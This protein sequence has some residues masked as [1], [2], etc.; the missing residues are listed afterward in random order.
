MDFGSNGAV[1]ITINGA[2]ANAD[3]AC[4]EVRLGSN[5][6]PL[7]TTANFKN[8][9]DWTTY[10]SQTFEIPRTVGTKDIVLV[11]LNG[12]FAFH[13]FQF[14][15]TD[16]RYMNPYEQLEPEAAAEDIEIADIDGGSH[17]IMQNYVSEIKDQVAIKFNNV[18]FGE[19]GS[20]LVVIKGRALGNADVKASI[21]YKD[22]DGN[23][24]SI[25]I[26]FRAGKGESYELSSETFYAQTFVAQ[27]IKGE[28]DLV[29]AFEKGTWFDLE[30]LYFLEYGTIGERPGDITE[31]KNLID[32]AAQLIESEYTPETWKLLQDALTMAEGF[33]SGNPY[34]TQT[35][36][37]EAVRT[38]EEAIVGLEEVEAMSEEELRKQIES[39]RETIRQ[40]EGRLDTANRKLEQ[41]NSELTEANQKLAKALKEL[42][43]AKAQKQEKTDGSVN[44]IAKMQKPSVKKGKEGTLKISW[45]KLANVRGY[46]IQYAT[47]KKFKGAKTKKVNA[48]KSSLVLKKL[49]KG[50]KYYVRIRAYR[51][52]KDYELYGAYSSA[53]SCKVKTKKKV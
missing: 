19:N 31:L 33:L 22:A 45:K 25:P 30:S 36:I 2:N 28:Q 32:S 11:F 29:V 26:I 13:Y 17:N 9:G 44:K 46:E 23:M 20:D 53:K 47:N 18:D 38:V 48:K 51:S 5:T 7:L 21:Q 27:G 52:A 40:L 12:S 3:D 1:K 4:I 42:E 24:Q 8:T 34:Y 14:T 35:Q 39:L 6:G 50:K 43:D 16:I 15:E 37:D 41:V 10:K 49:K